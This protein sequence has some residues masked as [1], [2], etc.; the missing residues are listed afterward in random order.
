LLERSKGG[1]SLL[2]R[3]LYIGNT[4]PLGERKSERKGKVREKIK[5]KLRKSKIN[6]RANKNKR[7]KGM[8]VK[9]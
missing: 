2:Y 8:G 3:G 9:Y 7:R 5:G 4:S 1:I 6:K